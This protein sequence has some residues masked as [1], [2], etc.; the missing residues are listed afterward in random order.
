[1]TLRCAFGAAGLTA[2]CLL[3]MKSLLHVTRS[4]CRVRAR[5]SMPESG[6]G[7]ESARPAPLALAEGN[8]ARVT[9]EE[10]ERTVFAGARIALLSLRVHATRVFTSPRAAV[11]LPCAPR[12]MWA[13]FC[14][15]LQAMQGLVLK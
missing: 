6:S 2:A 8:A 14:L 10:E 4:V 7:A 15:L 9:G 5:S 11:L 3:V 13:E 12:A 1:M